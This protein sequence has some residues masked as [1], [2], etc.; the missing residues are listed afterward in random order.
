MWVR[1]VTGILLLFAAAT[2]SGCVYKPPTPPPP[3]PTPAVL[4]ITTTYLPVA[5][6]GK[7]YEIILTASG[8]TPPYTWTLVSSSI[9]GTTLTPTGVLSLTPQSTSPGTIEVKVTDSKNS[10]SAF[11]LT[12][13]DL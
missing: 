4:T 5:Y 2:F 6:M 1:S 8:G 11:N 12:I 13:G 9:A 3:P 7:P 10:V